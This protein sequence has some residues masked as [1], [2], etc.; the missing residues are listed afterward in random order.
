[1]R[2][3]QDEGA[4]DLEQQLLEMLREDAAEPPPGA[5][6]Q[7]LG[8]LSLQLGLGAAGSVARGA[9]TAEAPSAV[10]GK[11]AGAAGVAG[12]ATGAALQL[13]SVL[14]LTLV[15]L[16]L[17]GATAAVS[18][19]ASLDSGGGELPRSVASSYREDMKGAPTKGTAPAPVEPGEVREPSG[20][21]LQQRRPRSEVSV[22]LPRP[23]VSTDAPPEPAVAR[24]EGVVEPQGQQVAARR[25]QLEAER[26]VLAA[27]RRSL[28]GGDA[29][30][31]LRLLTELN[32]RF[33]RLLLG[34]EHEALSIRALAASG[35]RAQARARAARFVALYPT[36]PLTPGVREVLR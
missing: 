34:Q 18:H 5:E 20:S 4:S 14:K 26:T 19:Y 15:G 21:A 23:S 13:T 7:V 17:G 29:A 32:R 3:W 27:A 12:S 6:E 1:M 16:L 35:A 22:A 25:S 33:P 9:G 30:G 10:A 24:F 28:Q 36:S 8:A 31:S 2:P 11:A